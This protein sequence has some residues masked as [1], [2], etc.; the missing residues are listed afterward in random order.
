MQSVVSPNG[1]ICH[2]FGPVEG[3]R[4]DALILTESSLLR[5]LERSMDKANGEAYVLYG[6]PAYPVNR[7]IL[8]PFRGAR[9]LT[10]QEELFNKDMSCVRAC[11]EWAFGK[12][13]R[14]FAFLDFSKNLKVLLQPV[15]KMYTI[16]AI[17][18]N[19]HTCLCG[20]QTGAYFGLD[21]P[22]L[23]TYLNNIEQ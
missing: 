1:M 21:P 7:H 10:Q 12:I 22:S 4:H 19:C 6:D 14:Y 13:V 15:G 18:A 9:R 20:S 2:L 8:A 17:L 16:G 23:E 3:R 11:V 5:I